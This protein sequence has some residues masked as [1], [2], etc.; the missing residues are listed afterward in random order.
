VRQGATRLGF[1]R[2]TVVLLTAAI[3]LVLPAAAS[4]G[5]VGV[6][7]GELEFVASDGVANTVTVT[8]GGGQITIKDAGQDIQILPFADPGCTKPTFDSATCPAVTVNVDAGDLPDTVDASAALVTGPT[9]AGGV[10]VSGGD[11]NDTLI[12]CPNGDTLNGDAGDDTIEGRDG[13]DSLTGGD[14]NDNIKGGAGDDALETVTFETLG[15]DT[16]DGGEGNDDLVNSLRPPAGMGDGADTFNGG[17]G[18]DTADYHA[19]AGGLSISLDG[20]PNDG[21]AGEGDNIG[22]DVEDLLGGSGNDTLVGN[23][24]DNMISAGGGDDT[25]MAMGGADQ[26][27]GGD[28]SG[29]DT[30]DGGEGDDGISGGAG[31]DKL[32]GAGGSDT[33][34]GNGGTDVESGGD[35]ADTVAGGA[36]IDTVDGDGG[37]DSLRGADAA[38]VG[39]DAADTIHGGPGAD[40]LSGEGGDDVLDGGGDG[41][42]MSGG[43]GK[44]VVDYR[45]QQAPVDI[46]ID[47]Q[48]NDGAPGEHDNV[49]TDVE[50]VHGGDFQTTVVGNAANNDLTGGAG[51]DYA[52]GSAG[53][54]VITGGNGADTLRSRD[55]VPDSVECGPGAYDFAIAD[56]ADSVKPSCEITDLGNSKPLSG[57]RIVVQPLSTS[58]IKL[59]H[60]HRFVPLSDRVGLPVRSTIEP[61]ATGVKLTA[62]ARG[63]AKP[64]GTFSGDA[65]L[66][67]QSKG[68]RLTELDLAGAFNLSKCPKSRGS[69]AAKQPQRR[70]FGNAHGHFVTR[71]RFSSATVRGTRWSI[72]DRCDGTLTHV[73]QGSVQVRDFGRHRTVTVKAGHSYLARRGNR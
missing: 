4:A 21:Y 14:G 47:D 55:G 37:N 28:D 54:D 5:T 13:D 59:D 57:R 12:G 1:A 63:G 68:S 65:F 2:L 52:D 67:K 45:T 27:S 38:G 8:G 34:D 66:V 60:V 61:M 72:E 40:T 7:G 70:L 6:N 48:P 19:S 15:N 41:D 64:S 3:A 36:G 17:P 46:K 10:F 23:N 44:D 25:V 58:F 22:A 56:P 20:I 26:L 30:L 50:D 43:D 71:G 53:S 24:S 73:T 33:I 35:G 32:S 18:R 51:E 16:L 31:D 62:A 29:S 9:P 49:A 42:L 69:A 11:G 39:A